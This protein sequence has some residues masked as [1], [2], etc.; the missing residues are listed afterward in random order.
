[1]LRYAWNFVMRVHVCVFACMYGMCVCLY[2][3][4]CVQASTGAHE[5]HSQPQCIPYQYF[6][7]F[8][9]ST[10]ILCGQL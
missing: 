10:K 5:S 1:M 4:M 3:C 9:T 2:V 8:N 7:Q 6:I